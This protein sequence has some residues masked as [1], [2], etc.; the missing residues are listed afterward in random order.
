MPTLS[1]KV[2]YPI[3]IAG[4]FIVVAFIAINYQSLTTGFYVVLSLLTIYIFLFGFATGENFALPIKKLLKKAE[5]L[6]QGNFKSR[7]YLND[8]DELGQLAKVFNKL[9]EQLEQI[10]TKAET[11]EKT[12]DIKVKAKTQSLE[13][14]IN[15]L[16]QKVKNR[17][18]E[19][20]RLMAELQKYQQKSSFKK[21]AKN[22]EELK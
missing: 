12:V 22:K 15:A 2:A 9:A 14:T 3:I 5:E 6:T 19:L 11:L 20:Q 17:T 7:I 8:K 13:E 21:Q 10:E 16:D 4:L 18:V 1:L